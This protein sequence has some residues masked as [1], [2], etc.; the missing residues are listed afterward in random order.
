MARRIVTLLLLGLL[1]FLP[2][3]S[4]Q[5]PMRF[6]HFEDPDPE[7]LGYIFEGKVHGP[8]RLHVSDT[9]LYLL[10]R[11]RHRLYIF[12]LSGNVLDS[13]LFGFCPRDL[14]Y[15]SQGKFHI[16]QTRLRPPQYVAA[17]LGAEQVE[18]TYFDVPSDEL[19]TGITVSPEGE[20]RVLTRGYA[21]ELTPRKKERPIAEIAG[22]RPGRFHLIDTHISAGEDSTGAAR[23]T[24]KTA[25]GA[26]TSFTP[27]PLEKEVFQ[28]L[29]DDR[30]GRIY[31]VG[32]YIDY[33][34]ED[35]AYLARRL[36]VVKNGVLLAEIKDMDAGHS[37]YDYANHDIAVAPNGDVYLWRTN[38]W[39]EHSDI[40]LWRAV[41]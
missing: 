27:S 11:Y 13:V 21:Y 18:K 33:D 28:F 1:R 17:Y 29:T 24:G 19:M 37:S 36:L 2:A 12:D 22:E 3:L 39:E 4:Y 15:D 35:K 8:M 25:S 16:L 40:L 5:G 38:Y 32:T 6:A 9:A 14:T 20:I 34:E 30:A 41:P 10:A 23:F 7:G 31:I 26:V